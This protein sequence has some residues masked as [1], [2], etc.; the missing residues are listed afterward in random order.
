MRAKGF[1]LI[2][3]LVVIFILTLVSFFTIPTLFKDFNI[4]EEIA[5]L[6]YLRSLRESAITSKKEAYLTVDF[7]ER[8]FS[9]KSETGEKKL[10]M[11]EDENWELFI[12]G[13]GNI[14]DGQV[15]ITFPPFP[16]EDFLV[17]YLRRGG[18]DFTIFL[19]NIT[20]EVELFK[21]NREFYD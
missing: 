10:L 5:L 12:P 8:F 4:K 11:K 9:F 19:N 20:G 3:L 16:S 7:K 14:K 6:T 17:F 15:I 21:E 18:K 2:E 13:R 1:T